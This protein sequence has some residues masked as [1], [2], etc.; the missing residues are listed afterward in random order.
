MLS[1]A[2]EGRNL[3]FYGMA[4][5]ARRSTGYHDAS[6]ESRE[7]DNHALYTKQHQ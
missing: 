4:P 7:E 3:N 5:Q 2:N 6:E 1:N